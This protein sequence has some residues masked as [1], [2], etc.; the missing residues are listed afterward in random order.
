MVRP[1]FG[2][3]DRVDIDLWIQDQFKDPAALKAISDGV[4]LEMCATHF[5][6]LDPEEFDD[7][8]DLIT[9][10]RALS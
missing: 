9:E 1:E 8:L 7:I 10:I 5:Y 2:L 6:G 3:M 4:I